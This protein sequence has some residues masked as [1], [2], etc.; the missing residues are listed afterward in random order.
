[1]ERYQADLNREVG[2][3]VS[4]REE[5]MVEIRVAVHDATHAPALI[6][7]LAG[8]FDR[9]AISFDSS[10]K[11]VRVESEWE[12][13]GVVHVVDAVEAWLAEDGIA[14]ATLSIGYR[15]YTLGGPF[16]MGR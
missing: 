1:L 16:A 9:S 14:S 15:S 7:R 13:R 6:G 4:T 2:D 11:E 5:Q 3:D 8:L 10:R 12:S